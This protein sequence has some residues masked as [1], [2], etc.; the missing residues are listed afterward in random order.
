MKTLLSTRDIAIP[1]GGTLLAARELGLF[2]RNGVLLVS[3]ARMVFRTS[4]S[5]L[6]LT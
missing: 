1:D 2:G 3:S 5:V 6:P 4:Y